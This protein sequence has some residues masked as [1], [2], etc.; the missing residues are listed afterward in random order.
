MNMGLY[1][2]EGIWYI[3]LRNK[4][5]LIRKSTDTADKRIA[6]KHHKKVEVAILEGKWFDKQPGENKT[7]TQLMEK[8]LK[9][10]SIKKAPKTMIRDRSLAAHLKDCFGD[11]TLT[12]IEPKH[13]SEYKVQRVKEGAAPKTINNEL[14]LMS[15]A[16]NLARKEYGWVKDNP[17]SMVKKEKVKNQRD[18]WLTLEEEGKLLESSPV[19]LQEIIK[20]GAN[21][22][23]RTSEMLNLKWSEIDM[24]RRTLTILEQKN[25]D[26]DTLPL[27][28]GAMAALKARAKVRNI[29]GLVFYN[30]AGNII[31]QSNLRRTLDLAVK[32]AGILKATPHDLRRTF[33][34]RLMQ[35]GCD[36]F[37]LKKLGRWKSLDMVLRYAH[38]NPE[39]LRN[40]VNIL[41]NLQESSTKKTQLVSSEM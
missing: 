35:A 14:F 2:R 41:D 22:G 15:H 13:V 27:N 23:L 32:K 38:H 5:R 21:T 1:Q 16:F 25:G 24:F 31:D 6:E 10:Y 12:A 26:K 28:E 33:A 4:G 17:V 20:F 37:A 34:T 9:E 11:Y 8:Y 36:L 39:S 29:N 7:F 30:S 3:R 18:R 40:S 19:W